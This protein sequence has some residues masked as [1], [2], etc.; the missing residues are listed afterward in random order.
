MTGTLI[1]YQALKQS[2]TCLDI[3][4]AHSTPRIEPFMKNRDKD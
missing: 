1:D 3:K 4:G 2:G